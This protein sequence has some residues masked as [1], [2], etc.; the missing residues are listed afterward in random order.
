MKRDLRM[1]PVAGALLAAMAS[2]DTAPPLR[3]LNCRADLKADP[4]PH[5]EA[6]LEDKDC[7]RLARNRIRPHKAAASHY[8]HPSC[9]GSPGRDSAL[10]VRLFR[11]RLPPLI[12][13]A[14]LAP[15][16]IM[17]RFGEQAK[18][19]LTRASGMTCW[20]FRP[21][22]S[23]RLW[24]SREQTRRSPGSIL[25]P[26]SL[27][28]DLSD[29]ERCCIASKAISASPGECHRPCPGNRS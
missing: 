5:G 16:M 18:T 15:L 7:A 9:M 4:D 24:P 17:P 12:T 11:G 21:S 3:G 23:P 25:C 8:M 28:P 6:S 14:F 22:R 20:R 27:W 26:M 1:L 2:D 10:T 19:K 29:R 13:M